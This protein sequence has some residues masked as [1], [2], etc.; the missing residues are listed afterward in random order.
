L[1]NENEI[2]SCAAFEG[3]A[4]ILHLDLS[5]NKLQNLAGISN[6]PHLQVLDVSENEVGDITQG[7]Q[8]LPSL[9]KIVLTKNKVAT[10][11]GFPRLPAL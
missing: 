5:K 9:R 8:K 2:A 7:L 1:L 3:H 11:N 10:L 4:A 6:M